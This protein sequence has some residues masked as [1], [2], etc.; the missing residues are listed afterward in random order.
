MLRREYDTAKSQTSRTVVTFTTLTTLTW[1]AEPQCTQLSSPTGAVVAKWTSTSSSTSKTK[2]RG[3]VFTFYQLLV[4]SSY[5]RKF[6]VFDW[7]SESTKFF[8]LYCKLILKHKEVTDGPAELVI[9]IR[10]FYLYTGATSAEFDLQKARAPLAINLKAESWSS[11]SSKPAARGYVVQ[12][13][14]N[15][16]NN[17]EP[18]LLFWQQIIIILLLYHWKSHRKTTS[19]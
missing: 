3:K 1:T 13:T 11:G 5:V 6:Q 19:R 12:S 4:T 8:S 18:K 10:F 14:T 15:K 2:R 17:D 7:S 9:F 16:K